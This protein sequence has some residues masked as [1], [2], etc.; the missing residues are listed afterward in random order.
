[1]LSLVFGVLGPFLLFLPGPLA[2]LLGAM[3]LVRRRKGEGKG[4]AVAGLTLGLLSTLG[5][6]VL[7]ALVHAVAQQLGSPHAAPSAA[8]PLF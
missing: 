5:L 3:A 1:M 7:V 8:E 6:V 2:A 4:V